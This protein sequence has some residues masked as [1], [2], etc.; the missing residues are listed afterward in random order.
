[1]PLPRASCTRRKT[2]LMLR[3][4]KSWIRRVTSL[5]CGGN[6][7]PT[8]GVRAFPPKSL[9][10]TFPRVSLGANF[11]HFE[12]RG[13]TNME[14]LRATSDD[15]MGK[16]GPSPSGCGANRSILR[17]HPRLWTRHSLR[18][19]PRLDRFSSATTPTRKLIT[20]SSDKDKR[21]ARVGHPGVAAIQKSLPRVFSWD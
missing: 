9:L 17:C 20:G 16:I 8:A 11:S 15:E 19:P 21:V 12:E 5:S 2:K 1:V 4:G 13:A 3:C 6:R 10:L 14:Y 18:I 7:S